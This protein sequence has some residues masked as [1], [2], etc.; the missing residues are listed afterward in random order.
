[1]TTR[2]AKARLWRS[3]A[4]GLLIAAP[5]ASAQPRPDA[6]VA[7]SAP[8]DP[9]LHRADVRR[10][11]DAVATWQ[12][13]HLDDLG[14]ITK[15]REEAEQ[16]RGWVQGTL[17]I[18]VLRWAEASN[19]AGL[20]R[21]V[22]S[23]AEANQYRLGDRLYHADDHAVARVYLALRKAGLADDRALTSARAYFNAILADP[24]TSDLRFDQ[25]G[26][27]LSPTN[28]WSWCDALFMAPPAWFEL[29]ALTGDPR[30][31][32]FADREF[33]ATTDYLFDAEAGFFYRDSRFIGKRG[34][35]G[36]KLFWGRGNGWVLAGLVA[37]LESMPADYPDRPRYE[38]LFRHMARSLKT[39]QHDQG[40]W[41]SSLLDPN[42]PEEMSGTAFFVYGIQRGIDMKLLPAA[43]YAPVVRRGWGALVRAVQPDGRLG[44]VQQIGDAPE[45]VRAD[46]SELYGTGAFLLAASALYEATAP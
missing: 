17:Y 7:T 5:P 15:Y 1:M 22:R 27:P 32:A 33:W 30:Y 25:P 16:K 11:A 31:R 38:A 4:L 41:S 14:Y 44:Y 9:A 43:D 42:A 10:V 39:T 18:G 20:L 13:G 6:A 21:R 45:A 12:F 35:A 26:A 46:D 23:W 8:F 29:S 2:K 34:A 19:S 40:Y 37:L 36:E 3:A 24:A 28:R